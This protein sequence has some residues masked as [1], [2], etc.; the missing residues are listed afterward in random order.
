MRTTKVGKSAHFCFC[1]HIPHARISPPPPRH[2][3]LAFSDL[4]RSTG[5]SVEFIQHARKNDSLLLLSSFAFLLFPARRG[6]RLRLRFRLRSGFLPQLLLQLHTLGALAV[7]S[8]EPLR[9]PRSLLLLHPLEVRQ[10]SALFGLR[11][12]LRGHLF[13]G[14]FGQHLIARFHLCQQAVVRSQRFGHGFLRVRRR[15]P[16]V[17]HVA[18]VHRLVLPDAFHQNLHPGIVEVATEETDGLEGGVRLQHACKGSHPTQVC[19]SVQRPSARQRVRLQVQALQARY[20]PNTARRHTA[21]SC[22]CSSC[23][24]ASV[25]VVVVVAAAVVTGGRCFRADPHRSQRPPEFR[26]R[27]RPQ[28]V[29][30]EFELL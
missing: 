22:P 27:S 9:H 11:R 14:G 3:P 2:H 8:L 29:A 24:L 12:P 5:L 6:G 19:V 18:C 15:V 4:K 26:Q 23:V 21:C 17:P 28:A 7:Q 13:G 16:C 20:L 30:A 10:P 1:A 25:V